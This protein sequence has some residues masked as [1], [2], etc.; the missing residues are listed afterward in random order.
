MNASAFLTTASLLLVL[1][2]HLH[3]ASVLFNIS[4]DGIKEVSSG[5]ISNGDADGTA[6]GTLLLDNGTGAALTGSA[7]LSLTLTNI[8]L[9]ALSGHHIHQ[10]PS[11]T[12]G[13]IVLDFGDPD[14]IRTGNVLSG[15]F[16]GLSATTISNILAN[17]TGF[18]Y[19]LHNSTFPAGA[20]RDQLVPESSTAMLGCLGAIGFALRRRR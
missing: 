18:Y 6:I 1:P 17:P 15:T 16:T 13:P 10:A 4:A 12:T 5:G 2:D 11:T 3:A 19:N 14:N 20:V 9:T 8:D 7:I